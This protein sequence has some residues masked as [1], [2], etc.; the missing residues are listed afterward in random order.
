MVLTKVTTSLAPG[1]L[2]RG[3]VQDILDRVQLQLVVDLVDF[4]HL[5]EQLQASLLEGIEECNDR[6]RD[7]LTVLTGKMNIEWLILN[8]FNKHR[9]SKMLDGENNPDY[10]EEENYPNDVRQWPLCGKVVKLGVELEAVPIFQVSKPTDDAKKM[11]R[12]RAT[13]K[14]TAAPKKN[15]GFGSAKY[16]KL[17]SSPPPYLALPDGNMTLAEITAFLPQLLKCWDIIDRLLWNGALA[18][19]L[20]T[21]INHFRDMPTG[22]I[23]SNTVNVMMR[24]AISKRIENEPAPKYVGWSVSKHQNIDRPADFDPTSVSVTGFRTPVNY[25][26]RKTAAAA[27]GPEPTIS[28]RDL[29]SGAKNMPSGDDALDLTRCVEYCVANP[30]EDWN[31]PHD[32][33]ELVNHLGGPTTVQAG[34]QDASIVAR[35]TSAGKLKGANATSKR[36]RDSHG[37][38]LKK[39]KANSDDNEAVLSD[40]DD[41]S[42]DDDDFNA[43]DDYDDF[44]LSAKAKGKRPVVSTR[45]NKRKRLSDSDSDDLSIIESSIKP[46]TKRQKKEQSTKKSSV[47]KTRST[48]SSPRNNVEPN[49]VLSDSES[50]AYEGPKNKKKAAVATRTSGRSTRKNY[51]V[52][53]ALKLDGDEEEELEPEQEEL[54]LAD[55]RQRMLDRNAEAFQKKAAKRPV[56]K[57]TAAVY[58]DS[59]EE[60]DGTDE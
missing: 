27:G 10:H 23:P 39:N 38:L 21:M 17:R 29:A 20:A 6:D 33:V 35:Y 14:E 5:L 2:S 19:T 60:D 37:R 57:K 44:A 26:K 45:D 41:Q 56:Q 32:F 48:R 49:N 30:D 31:Y 3:E 11:T 28:F 22:A 13:P 59:E 40:S 58:V 1:A 53:K 4:P 47:R 9:L 52:E 12:S 54:T 55:I 43:L 51:K 46:S 36:D 15:T 24:G 42:D 18:V 50:D 25:N 34:H 16:D 8:A 7:P